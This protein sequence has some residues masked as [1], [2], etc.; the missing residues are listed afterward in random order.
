MPEPLAPPVTD[1]TAGPLWAARTTEA[2][3]LSIEDLYISLL[4]RNLGHDMTKWSR[5]LF[6]T[7][8]TR[9]TSLQVAKSAA[10]RPHRETGTRQ[11]AG[12]PADVT[13]EEEATLGPA[14]TNGGWSC[15]GKHRQGPPF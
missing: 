7:V 5:I 11:A 8:I 3:K 12:E 4:R 13:Q 14:E 2:L 10:P 15:C 1:G 6:G 9:S